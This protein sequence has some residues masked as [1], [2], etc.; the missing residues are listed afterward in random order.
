MTKVAIL[1]DN[2][3]P[4][5]WVRLEAASKQCELLGIELAGRSWEY[6]WESSEKQRA[7]TK[8][9]ECGSLQVKSL[10]EGTS[11]G[12]SIVEFR[13]RLGVV[14]S[15][16]RPGVVV[17]P[18]WATKA[19]LVSLR[20]SLENQVPAVLL[21]DSQAIDER[22]VWWKESVK[23]AIVRC[24]S[25]ALVAGQQHV[26]YAAQL[27]MPKDRVFLG[28]DAVDNGY[29]AAGAAKSREQ[30]AENRNKYQLPEHYFL[31][32]ARFVEKKNLLRLLQAYAQYRA[33]CQV[34]S[35]KCEPWG[36]VLLGDGELRGKLRAKSEELG[37]SKWV[38]MPGFKQYPDLPAH[39]GLAGAFIHAS[40]TEQWGL[41][42]N[43]A[44][45]CG[46]P[47]LVSNRCGC[48]PDLV[49]NGVNGFTFDPYDVEQL[50]QLMLRLAETP[51]HRL[52]EMADASRAIISEWG[53]DRFASGLKQAVEC[54]LRVGPIRPTLMQ[55]LILKA[56]LSR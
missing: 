19:A 11:E 31:A 35:A 34:P 30:R 49:Q 18:G 3:G 2:F 6:A 16:F 37:V 28:Y 46:L 26:A 38:Q 20:W 23:S 13:K 33:K 48:A 55:K 47:V 36:L 56:L 5:H 50:A 41:V 10:F 12:L 21:S 25:S 1:F 54:A 24:F 43:E 4:Y 8:E 29:F 15:D 32:S 7:E 27:G 9:Q 22:R 51:K 52:T 45:A 17:V 14:L 42:V 44:M 53:P 40:T 39:Y